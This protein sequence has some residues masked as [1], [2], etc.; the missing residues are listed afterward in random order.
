MK[1]HTKN[2]T[3][4]KYKQAALSEPNQTPPSTKSIPN[5]PVEIPRTF[6]SKKSAE[7]YAEQI[8]KLLFGL[9]IDSTNRLPAM[10]NLLDD[11]SSEPEVVWPV[12]HE[13]WNCCEPTW[14]HCDKLLEFLE[15]TEYSYDGKNGCPRDYL[16]S[17]DK[18]EFKTL[19]E[20]IQIYRG[21]SLSKVYGFSWTTNRKIAEGFAKGYRS[22]SVP[23]PVIASLLI[24]KSEVIGFYTSRKESEVFINHRHF[25]KSEITITKFFP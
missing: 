21:C 10:L 8:K 17:A 1:T 5:D 16:S 4:T 11:Y 23:D 22:I 7:V 18:E 20:N 3:K 12:F 2:K 15:K 13:V 6:I 14:E 19:P 9:G 24:P 25:E